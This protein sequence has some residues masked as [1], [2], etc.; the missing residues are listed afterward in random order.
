MDAIVAVE[1][2]GLI[3]G[4]ALAYRLGIG[5]VLV[6]K[7][8]KLPHTTIKKT[9]SLEYGE[10]VLEVHDDS[11]RP[12]MRVVLV[13][14]LLATGGTMGAVIGLT[15]HFKAQIVELAFLVELTDLHGRQMLTPHPT[16]ALIQY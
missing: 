15:E 3:F 13:D 2:R 6:R 8:G 9:Y 4:A 14:D 7:A 16:F 10:G 1:S 12:G 5:L 11:L